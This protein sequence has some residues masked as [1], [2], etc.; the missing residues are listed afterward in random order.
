MARRNHCLLSL[1]RAHGYAVPSLDIRPWLIVAALALLC[2]GW[3]LFMVLI[4]A[5]L[6]PRERRQPRCA[7]PDPVN[8]VKPMVRIG[9]PLAPIW[10]PMPLPIVPVSMVEIL[11]RREPD[12][13]PK[14]AFVKGRYVQV[15]KTNLASL[16]LRA[17]PRLVPGGRKLCR[18]ELRARL[19]EAS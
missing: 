7:A 19:G 2:F 9:L 12:K 13:R 15:T 1:A 10:H 3:N 6:V 11:R 4:A 16:P 17:L 5:V 14:V 18:A 8:E